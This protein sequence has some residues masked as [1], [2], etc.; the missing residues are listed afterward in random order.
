MASVYRSR[1]A[2]DRPKSRP[3]T[4]ERAKDRSR[5]RPAT[6]ERAKDRP[7]ARPAAQERTGTR[8][9]RQA[10]RRQ[11]VRRRR[12]RVLLIGSVVLSAL[13]VAA[14]FPASAL[15][16]QHQQLAS[17]TARLAQVR[18]TD[19]ALHQEERRLGSSAE[20]ARIAREQYQLVEPGQQAYEVLPPSNG[21]GGSYDGDPGLQG[22][23]RPSAASELPPGSSQQPAAAGG[24]GSSGAGSPTTGGSSG[25]GHG[26]H[27]GAAASGG[28]GQPTSLVG[29]ITQTLEFWR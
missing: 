26:G 28:D 1:R 24:H 12:E 17:T 29:R 14:W 4:K 11:E 23:V 2:K 8:S 18:S 16:H 3:V 15:Y 9:Q 19:A 21:A 20:V 5:A 27:A 22:P 25:S 13:V 7:R 10:A 6:K